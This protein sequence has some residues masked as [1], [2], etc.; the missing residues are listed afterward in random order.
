MRPSPK[1]DAMCRRC[2]KVGGGKPP[3]NWPVIDAGVDLVCPHCINLSGSCCVC[4]S[5][6]VI[7]AGRIA[8]LMTNVWAR[9][10]CVCHACLHVGMAPSGSQ[11]VT[12]QPQLAVVRRAS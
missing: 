1:P 2:W 8:E 10:G 9:L 7:A 3:A 12:Q 4:S 5:T 6:R 11:D